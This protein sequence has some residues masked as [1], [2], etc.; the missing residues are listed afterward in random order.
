MEVKMKKK[1][2]LI[3]ALLCT[4]LAATGCGTKK[5]TNDTELSYDL[6]KV[7]TLGTYT[8]IE[9][10]AVG[11]TV[12]DGDTVNIDYVG[13]KDGEAFDGGTG[14]YDL[15][16]GSGT[17]ISGFEEGLIGV[18]VGETVDLDLT[19]PEDY[20]SEE[21]AGQDVVFTVTVNEI[22][23]DED[24]IWE[25]AVSNATVNEYPE[26]ELEKAYTNME[27]YYKSFAEYYSM[28]YADLLSQF[29]STEETFREDFKDVV[30]ENISEKLV[31]LAIAKKEN[32]SISDDEYD[33]KAAEYVE[34]YGYESTEAMEE[35]VTKEVI[36]EQMLMEKARQFVI[37]NAVTK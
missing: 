5:T 2:L 32:L 11:D 25:Q 28:E 3:A 31:A 20:S 36:L 16:I 15:T 27:N 7:V 33:E 21:L 24:A 37:D 26:S 30:E 4:A 18:K 17:F 19:F 1:V 6:D 29:G 23:E 10:E 9:K 14:N 12:K 22:V 8:G 13:K 34:N 35:Q